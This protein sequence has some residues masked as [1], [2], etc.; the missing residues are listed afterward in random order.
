[1]NVLE[2]MPTHYRCYYNILILLTFILTA[3]NKD[4]IVIISSMINF[5]VRI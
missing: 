5:I 2:S 3:E 4:L 1:M